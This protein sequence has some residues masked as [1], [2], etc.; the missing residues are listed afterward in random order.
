MPTP[1]RWLTTLTQL[2]RQHR[3]GCQRKLNDAVRAETLLADRADAVE[4]QMAELAALRRRTLA[5][6][7]CDLNLLLSAQRHQAALHRE[8]QA[9]AE[10][11]DLV[12][13]EVDRRRANVVAAERRVRTLEKLSERRVQEA[14][15]LADRR[16]AKR[17]DELATIMH[18]AERFR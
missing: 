4:L 2:R 13:Q 16:E 6:G 7:G 5:G 15:R 8:Q 17:L 10:Q 18:K 9:T 14:I 12:R 3:D 11:L 1:P